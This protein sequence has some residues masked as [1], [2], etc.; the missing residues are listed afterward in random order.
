MLRNT[1]MKATYCN[2]KFLQMIIFFYWKH[3]IRGLWVRHLL[4]W[5]NCQNRWLGR[6]LLKE[7]VCCKCMATLK[8]KEK[9][10]IDTQGLFFIFFQNVCGKSIMSEG[11]VSLF[12]RLAIRSCSITAIFLKR[13]IKLFRLFLNAERLGR[14]AINLYLFWKYVNT[15]KVREFILGK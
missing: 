9:S 4:R 7:R 11:N 2:S 1:R 8:L 14:H 10:L 12:V 5:G 6:N 13:N 15:K 3:S